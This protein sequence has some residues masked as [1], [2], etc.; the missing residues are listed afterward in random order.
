M[1]TPETPAGTVAD[2]RLI[3]LP[4]LL[5]GL[6]QI[7]LAAASGGALPR[8]P[9]LIAAGL[10]A[11]A[12][13]C[14]TLRKIARMQGAQQETAA[15][16][17]SSSELVE[18]ILPIWGKQ[19]DTGRLETEEA[20][21]A[22]AGRFS[23]LSGRLQ[24]AVDQ[25]QGSSGDEGIVA[26]LHASQKDL[27]LI[28]DAMKTALDAMH[29]MMAQIA[30]LPQFTDA[31]KSMAADVASVA[32][33]TNLV[34]LNA[35]IEAARAGEAG[36]GF[37]VVAGEVRRLSNLSAETGK[38]INS[39]VEMVSVSVRAVLADAEQYAQHESSVVA[40]SETAIRHVLAQFGSTAETLA[41]STELLQAES[42]GIRVEIDDVLVALQF[43]DRVSQ[44]FSH[45][46]ND[47][48]KLHAHLLQS[49]AGQGEPGQAIDAARWLA[50][51]ESTYTT[52][53]Q[54]RNHSGAAAQPAEAASEI[55]FF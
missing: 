7:A 36:R 38:K 3:W 55:T 41:R 17:A 42:A 48:D 23:N 16:A 50:E 31:L 28:I 26:L 9:C 15:A 49:R 20:V 19:I 39:T 52:A 5:A 27:Q 12:S 47:L 45:V 30:K 54:R 44:I 22:L 8:L 25:S 4:L 43:Q 24:M 33:Q 1:A 37:A 10:V 14:W 34:A 46:Q 13:I 18:S 21:V 35:A 51:L 40:S 32:A 53:E 11:A 2:A 29:S 6:A